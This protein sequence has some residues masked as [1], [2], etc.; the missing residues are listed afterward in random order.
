MSGECGHGGVEES[1]Y[2]VQGG[3]ISKLVRGPR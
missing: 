3:G 1:E 2:I